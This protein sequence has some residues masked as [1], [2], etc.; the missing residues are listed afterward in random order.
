MRCFY[1]HKVV[2][3]FRGMLGMCFYETQGAYSFGITWNIFYFN[4]ILLF[5]PSVVQFF[6][7]LFCKF[8]FKKILKP[9]G[10]VTFY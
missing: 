8:F 2:P 3:T 1:K 5:S 10:L 4:L 9:Q 7:F 6:K